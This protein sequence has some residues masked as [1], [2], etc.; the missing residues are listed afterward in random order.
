MTR[1]SVDEVKT[2]LSKP[3]ER[4]LGD[5]LGNR[6]KRFRRLPIDWHERNRGI[7]KFG[8]DTRRA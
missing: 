3:R 5:N 6:E 4:Y 2:A 7:A 8:F 1:V